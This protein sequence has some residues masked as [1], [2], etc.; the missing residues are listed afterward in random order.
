LITALDSSVLL[1]VLLEDRKH[2]D[3]SLAAL[4]AAHAGGALIACPVV[5]SEVRAAL[6]EPER[7]GEHLGAAGIVF[8]PF[9]QACADLAGDL[10]RA[11]RR[12]GWRREHLVPDFLIGAHAKLRADRLL[13]RDRGFF[14]RRFA[15]LTVIDPSAS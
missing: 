12:A 10:W 2:R 15:G 8:D 11:Y 13:A 4:V 14:Q 9:D 7:I 6:R 3:R 5:W 1:D